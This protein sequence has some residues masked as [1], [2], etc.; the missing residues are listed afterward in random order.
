MSKKGI[1]MKDI[2]NMLGV[3][4]VTVSK[5]LADKDG[6][7]EELKKKIK[8]TAR[9]LGYRNRDSMRS[10]SA[11]N[12]VGILVADHFVAS[13]QSFYWD[14]YQSIVKSLRQRGY[15]AMLEMISVKDEQEG[16]IPAFVREEK[17]DII[18]VLGWLG[19]TYLRALDAAG[20]PLLYVDFYSKANRATA[21]IA[22]MLYDTYQMTEYLYSIGH[23]RIGFVGSIHATSD[24]EDRYLGYYKSVI[25]RRLPYQGTGCLRIGTRSLVPCRNESSNSRRTCP[26]PLSAT[27]MRPHTILSITWSPRD[28]VSLRMSP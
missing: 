3:S 8:E 4:T 10:G 16:N 9:E 25:R 1:K 17:V 5:A 26:R 28:F 11:T 23:R 18:F 19:R 7:S 2:A 12:T 14:I 15:Y 27:M 13:G 20:L 6:V 21:V 22:D 24:I